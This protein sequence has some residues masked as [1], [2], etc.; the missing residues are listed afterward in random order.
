MR[1]TGMVKAC[2]REDEFE[3][4]A[5]GDDRQLGVIFG[6]IAQ[7][8]QG[9]GSRLDFVEEEYAAR[10]QQRFTKKHFEFS[11]DVRQVQAL[12]DE[13]QVWVALEVDFIEVQAMGL[14]E[15]LH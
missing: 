5:S 9:M 8:G 10:C 14:G 6:E 1:P 4:G 15:L 13:I 11:A 7:G 3:Q 2:C 12:K